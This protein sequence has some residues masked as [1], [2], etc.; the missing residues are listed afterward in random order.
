MNLLKSTL[1]LGLLAV[2]T[3]AFSFTITY[4][5]NG[6]TKT[7]SK[8][9]YSSDSGTT[10]TKK[11]SYSTSS[12]TAVRNDEEL[13]SYGGEGELYGGEGELYGGNGE[14]LGGDGEP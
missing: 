9:S 4:K 11:L 2:S 5:V 7:Y 3:N 14:P 12:L 8:T 13:K 1:I 10:S 6:V